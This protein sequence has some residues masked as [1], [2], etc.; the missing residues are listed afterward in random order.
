[1]LFRG[2]PFF[3]IY[4]W[5][6]SKLLSYGGVTLTQAQA[7]N[8]KQKQFEPKWLAWEIT[9]KCNLNCIHCRSASSLGSDEGDFTLDEAKAFIDELTSFAQPVVVL[10]GGEPLLREDV[11]DIAAYGTSKG[12]RM[13]LATNGSL[14]NDE[15]CEKIKASGIRIVSLSLDG[16]TAEI[17]DDFRKQPGAFKSTLRAADFFKKHGIEF[18][19]NSSFTKRNQK[20]I[21]NVYKLAK[22]MGATAWYMFMIVPMGRGEDLMA[23]LISKEDYD[24]ILK[25]HFNM[26]LE[27]KDILVRPTCAPHYYRIVQQEAKAKGIDFERRNLKFG[28][29]GGKGCIAAQSIAFVGSRG[30]V[31]P[32]SYFPQSAGNVKKQH[33]KDIWENSKLFNDMRNFKDYKGRCGSCEYIG[34]CGVCRDRALD[35]SDDYMSEEN[36]CDHVPAKVLREMKKEQLDNE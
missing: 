7:S 6:K 1:M 23:E 21:P 30:D 14:V 13:A 4:P 3:I 17:H 31:Q 19:I 27:E 8:H 34:V 28:T 18:L 20:D 33:F 32:C 11:F 29:G 26:E 12:L 24:E 22:E 2:K 10:S 16:S 9:G 25:W 35:V 15:I 36:L 5:E